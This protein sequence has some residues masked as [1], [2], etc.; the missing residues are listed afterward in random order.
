[1][2]GAMNLSAIG[3]F[4]VDFFTSLINMIPKL[5]YLLYSSLACLL[6]IIQMAFRK[7][8]GLDVYFVNGQKVTGDIVTN[9]ITGILNI[10][11]D[12]LAYPVLTNV[13][14]AFIVFGL[15]MVFMTTIV[16][17]VKS[18]YSYDDKAAKG[19]MQYVYTAGKAVINM[20]AV[21]IIIVLGLY[22]N[23]AILT[24][25]DSITSTP[26]SSAISVYGNGK[27]YLQSVKDSK[28]EDTYIYY[29]IFG[30]SAKI[31]YGTQL[32]AIPDDTWDQ[33]Q[34]A[35]IGASSQPITGSLFRTA[36]FN[37]NRARTGQFWTNGGNAVFGGSDTLFK[38]A[39]SQEQLGQMI[40]TAFTCHLH[41]KERMPLTYSSPATEDIDALKFFTHFSAVEISSFSKFNIGAVW[42]YYDLWQF[43]F[44]IGFAAI[45]VTASILTN[46]TFGLIS[47]MFMCILLFLVA[48]PIFGLAPLDGGDSTKKWRTNFMKNVLMTY[49]AVVG[50]NLMFLILPYLNTID[51]FNIQ[52]ADVLMQTLIIIAGLITVKAAIA[53]VSEIIGGADA[54]ASGEKLAAETGKAALSGA[55]L[56]GKSAKF[57][58][59]S[60][61]MLVQG[62]KAIGGAGATIVKGF[63]TG[64]KGIITGAKAVG[65]GASKAFNGLAELIG[66]QKRKT[67]ALEKDKQNKDAVEDL[68]KSRKTRTMSKKD[69]KTELMTRGLSASEAKKN[70][71]QI[72]K[73]QQSTVGMSDQAFRKEARK[74]FKDTNTSKKAEKIAQK[75]HDK[76]YGDGTYAALSERDKGLFKY[77]QKND[78]Q[79]VTNRRQARVAYSTARYNLARAS[80]RR[81][82]NDTAAT[83]SRAAGNVKNITYQFTGF[84][85]DVFKDAYGDTAMLKP[86]YE[87]RKKAK[88]K[89]DEAAEKKAT[90]KYRHD[91]MDLL[92]Q[93]KNK[94]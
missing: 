39:T 27:D 40:D 65:A 79:A 29:D 76:V 25:V 58:A 82:A 43:N 67:R 80:L 42:Y 12:D 71:K 91:V 54:N 44:V 9:F 84:A 17:I 86:I 52:I 56:A 63:T 85:K 69:L 46:I 78:M 3:E 22:I 74:D 24:A 21:P 4:F 11:S 61:K 20:A 5:I 8:A 75:A 88:D 30:F 64:A 33:K 7:L 13:F 90:E 41:L 94:P 89:A 37:A 16:A 31:K 93:I 26:S 2:S 83:A 6:D 28:G 66:G 92:N 87:D 34:L 70:A 49:G 14:W 77:H 81:S 10:R 72:Y 62:A 36:A 47:R 45:V 53:V 23:Q 48:P 68:L 51:F 15:I 59:S 19:P 35:L 73:A 32:S 18:H 1:M 57:V 60:P 38:N 50:M 55:K